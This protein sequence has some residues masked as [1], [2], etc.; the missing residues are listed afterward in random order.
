MH[1]ENLDEK[2]FAKILPGLIDQYNNTDSARY[3]EKFSPNDMKDYRTD[4]AV[5]QML[6]EN[7][8]LRPQFPNARS[9][10]QQ[11]RQFFKNQII[12][13]KKNNQSRPIG[14]RTEKRFF[15]NDRVLVDDRNWSFHGSKNTRKSKIKRSEFNLKKKMEKVYTIYAVR[16][17]YVFISMLYSKLVKIILGFCID[18][19]LF[20]RDGSEKYY[21]L[22][23][24]RN[25]KEVG[26][27][28]SKNLVLASAK[29]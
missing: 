23:N 27:F 13:F 4:P 2:K 6:F 16:V 7:G 15:V 11:A 26:S 8:K 12:E 28:L 25:Q 1:F 5:R 22:K 9:G 3:N 10:S 29:K 19:F 24:D 18:F 21:K 14:N 17:R 20:F